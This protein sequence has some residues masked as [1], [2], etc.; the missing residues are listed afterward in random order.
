M[1]LL[2]RLLGSTESIA[3]HGEKDEQIILRSWKQYISTVPEKEQIINQLPISFGERKNLLRRLKKLLRL[4]LADVFTAEKEE[5]DLVLNLQSLEHNKK[6][7]KVHRL[8]ACLGYFETRHEYVYELLRHLY[9]VLKSEARLLEKLTNNKDIRKFRKL[10]GHLKSEFEV[11][12]TLLKKIEGIETFHNLFSALV[13]GEHTIHRMDSEEKRLIQKVQKEFTKTFAFL[14]G[15]SISHQITP[16]KKDKGLMNNWT[17]DVFNRIEVR[18]FLGIMD[19]VFPG[20]HPDIDFEF[21]NRPEFVLLVKKSYYDLTEK[22]VSDEVIN[23][24]VH[25]FREWYNH[26][27]D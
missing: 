18:V 17:I 24:F 27:R 21:V 12:Q 8:E 20:L 3:K 22:K 6:I 19:E 7:K 26:G 16:L 1:T 13:K 2:N 4:E 11:E 10:V 25:L 9:T 14:A 23:V 15:R 5:D